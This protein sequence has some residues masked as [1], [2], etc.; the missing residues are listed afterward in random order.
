[1]NS[2]MPLYGHCLTVQIENVRAFRHL[3]RAGNKSRCRVG[4]V[5]KV[6][7]AS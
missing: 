7:R 2:V 3:V 1:M 6:S 4:D 5:L